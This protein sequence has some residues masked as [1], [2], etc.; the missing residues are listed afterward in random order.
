MTRLLVTFLIAL[1]APALAGQEPTEPVRPPLEE[2]APQEE[3]EKA[4][5][6][7]QDPVEP[8]VPLTPEEEERRRKLAE[9]AAEKA[10][11]RE[12]RKLEREAKKE[13]EEAKRAEKEARQGVKLADHVAVL[14]LEGHALLEEGKYPEARGRFK[15]AN[16]LERGRSWEAQMGLAQTELASE[17]FALAVRDA[18]RAVGTTTLDSRK[19]EALTIAGTAILA[20]RPRLAEG[21]LELQP[22]AEMYEHAALRFFM[23][24]VTTAPDEATTARAHLE[25]RFPSRKASPQIARL[26]ERYLET[27]AEAASAHAVRVLAAYEAQLSQTTPGSEPVA[28]IGA[29]VPPVRTGGPGVE[30]SAKASEEFRKRLIVSFEVTADGEVRGVAVL[31]SLNSKQD[32]A[33]VKALEQWTYEPAQLP[34]GQTV[35]VFWMAGVDGGSSAISPGPGR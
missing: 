13:A 30:F 17:N 35:S 16:E 1:L 25:E 18:Q 23:R 33:V 19:A 4:T 24:A 2:S 5:E 29:I 27:G 14:I 9:A 8:E 12:Q 11:K 6:P 31:N 10:A 28:V 32:A 7:E 26:L 3:A 21:S 22:G 15:K 34:G 20:A